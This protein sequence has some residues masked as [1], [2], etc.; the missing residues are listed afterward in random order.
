MSIVFSVILRMEWMR[1]FVGSDLFE[2]AARVGRE[3]GGG[4]VR[5]GVLGERAGVEGVLEML[6]GQ[7][8]VQHRGVCQSRSG[9]T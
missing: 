4:E 3:A 5:L 1:T 7:G 9:S 6:E 2:P 8:E